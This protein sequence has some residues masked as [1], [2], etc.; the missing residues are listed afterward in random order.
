VRAAGPF[1]DSSRSL[2]PMVWILTIAIALPLIAMVAA[3]VPAWA[4]PRSALSVVDR[5][6]N[7]IVVT[8]IVVILSVS[9]G[10]LVALVLT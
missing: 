9:V 1:A 3:L 5:R 8:G 2:N 10:L 4:L 7:D 6:R